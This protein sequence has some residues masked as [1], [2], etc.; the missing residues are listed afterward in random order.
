MRTIT[1]DNYFEFAEALHCWLSLNHEGQSSKHYYLLCRSEFRPDQLWS[2][3][4]CE[5]ENEV[6]RLITEENFEEL[7]EEL[8]QVM[9][10]L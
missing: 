1:E 3:S 9:E 7:F 2:E 5:A 4:R 10:N 6:Y 8:N